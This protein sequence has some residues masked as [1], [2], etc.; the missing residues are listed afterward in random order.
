MQRGFVRRAP[1][2]LACGRGR[3]ESHQSRAWQKCAPQ[4]ISSCLTLKQ[5]RVMVSY[6]TRL[7]CYAM[8]RCAWAPHLFSF[9]QTQ[10]HGVRRR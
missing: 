3:R 7:V 5:D 6:T 4:I 1:C 10:M 8:P 9:T 2:S